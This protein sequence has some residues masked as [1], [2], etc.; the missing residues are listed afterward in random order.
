[1]THTFQCAGQCML[2]IPKEL[3]RNVP[4]KGDLEFT[5]EIKPS[6]QSLK[7]FK[8]HCL[9][10]S[11]CHYRALGIP[12]NSNQKRMNKSQPMKVTRKGSQQNNLACLD[13]FKK[14]HGIHLFPPHSSSPYS[15]PPPRPQGR[16]MERKTREKGRRRERDT[17]IPCRMCAGE[18]NRALWDGV[19]ETELRLLLWK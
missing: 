3:T 6:M 7:M 5:K 13:W 1:M 4:L 15:A 11:V 9:L 2:G 14:R 19:L 8:C 18:T 16:T 10:S 17:R 12:S